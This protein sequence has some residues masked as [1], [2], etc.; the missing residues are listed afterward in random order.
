M[1]D[2]GPIPPVAVVSAGEEQEEV[3]E[4]VPLAFLDDTREVAMSLQDVT[5]RNS[6]SSLESRR[7]RRANREN[8]SPRKLVVSPS[9][10]TLNNQTG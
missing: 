9:E 8:R 5:R 10:H 1:L 2:V 6:A 4:A 3:A 7:L